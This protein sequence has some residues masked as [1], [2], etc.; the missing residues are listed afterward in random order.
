MATTDPIML[1]R[2]RLAG[3][4]NRPVL[5]REAITEARRNLT[6]AKVER[7]VKEALAAVPAMTAEQRSALI[8]LLK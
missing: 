3:L 7:S 8:E 2:N 4:H 1:A 5:D 6:F